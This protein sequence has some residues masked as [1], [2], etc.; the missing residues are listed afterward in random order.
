MPSWSMLLRPPSITAPS[1]CLA[2]K[3]DMLQS[4][5][6]S[7]R[8]KTPCIVRIC[9]AADGNLSLSLSLLSLSHHGLL[10]STC[11]VDLVTTSVNLFLFFWHHFMQSRN[12]PRA[13]H[14]RTRLSTWLACLDLGPLP[15]SALQCSSRS[16]KEH[17]SKRWM[18]TC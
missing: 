11:H 14:A 9:S 4:S 16:R 6:S 15:A 1:R 7:L 10:Q 17:V 13:C 2:S 3:Q 5:C 12:E 18:C 8:C